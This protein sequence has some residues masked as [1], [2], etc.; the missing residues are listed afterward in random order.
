MNKV[1]DVSKANSFIDYLPGILTGGSIV[2]FMLATVTGVRATPKAL[3][4]IEEEKER[5]GE[6]LT[7]VETVQAGW[8]PYIPTLIFT[9]VGTGC[10][11]GAC[12]MQ[13][14]YSAA[15][16]GA[17]LAAEKALLSSQQF[18]TS[19][20]NEF[21]MYKDKVAE[22]IGEEKTNAIETEVQKAMIAKSPTAR[23]VLMLPCSDDGMELFKD[24]FTG[25]YFYATKE[26]IK[27]ACTMLNNELVSY[28]DVSLDDWCDAI[29][30]ERTTIGDDFIWQADV[31]RSKLALI[32]VDISSAETLNGRLCWLVRFKY[33]HGPK[34][35]NKKAQI[36]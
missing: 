31:E 32:E 36:R 16:L 15:L 22:V 2:S 4:L 5:K 28:T 27:D 29:G 33:G 25:Q 13:Y 24:G 18:L 30:I 6:D 14:K 23:E 8:K 11:I 26:D 20:I 35:V 1:S 34:H 9:G 3:Q 12:A 21:D 10:A 7:V 19:K 17:G